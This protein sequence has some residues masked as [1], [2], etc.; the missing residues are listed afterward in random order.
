VDGIFGGQIFWSWRRLFLTV[1]GQYALR[2]EGDFGYRYADDLTWVGGPGVFALL[3]HRHSLGVQAL[4][5][6]ETKGKDTLDDRRLDD[7]G[8]TALYAG[9]GF[10]FTWGSSLAADIAADLPVVQ[11]NTALQIVPDFRLRGGVTWRF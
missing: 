8:I 10:T 1:G 9:P 2:T 11:N 3:G 5:S 7:T 4:V 6:G